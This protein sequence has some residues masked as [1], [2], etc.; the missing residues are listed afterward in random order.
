MIRTGKQYLESLNDGRNVWVGNEK[1]DNVATH[2]K[3]RD[4]AQR[5]AD[6]YDL[7]HRPDLQDVMTFVD[8]DGER[9]T[10]QWFGHFDKEQLRRKRK[11]HETIMREMAGASFPRTPDVNNYV[12]QT[13]IDDPSPW[14]TQTIGAEGKVKAKN[15]VDFVN[16]AKKHDLNC[17]PQ[18]VDP[19]MDRSNPDAQQRSPGLRVIEKNDK[20]IVVSGVKAIGTGVA[21]A[22]W[23]HIGVFFRPGIPGDQIIFAATPVNTPGVTIVC[24]ESVVKEDPIEHPLAS[25]GDELDGMTVFDNVFIPWS[26]VFHLGNP[27]HAKLYPQRVFDWLHYHALIRQSVRAEL[28]AGLAILITEHI[29]TN[30]IPAVQTRVAKLIGFHQAMLAHIVASEELGF[31]TPGGAYKPNILIYDFGRA[32]YLENFSQ[33]IYELVDLSGRSALIFASED[34]WND[35]ALNGWFERMN[36]GPVGQPHDRVKIGRV[37]RDLFLTDWGNRLFVFENF[38]G[39]PL[40]AIRMLTMQRAEFSAAGPYGTLARKVCGIELS[41]GHESEYKATAG[42]AQALDSARQQEKLAL[43]GTMT[44]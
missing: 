28:M 40:Q 1:I 24:R 35:E 19:Q 37:I 34:Q 6:F 16:F 5:H 39:T 41:E 17:A 12:L 4:Y 21:F 14:E 25:Q 23:I 32:L 15:I 3:T 30:K 2:P 29:G 43:S 42:Y 44:V 18:F 8:K 36:N 11:Y 13:Y 26:H 38:N 10:M 33:M 27:E 22:D 7:H 20:G 9:R 31:H